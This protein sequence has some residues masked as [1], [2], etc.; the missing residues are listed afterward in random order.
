MSNA[1]DD[2]SAPTA[3]PAPDK[4]GALACVR[5]RIAAVADCRTMQ[6][7]AVSKT[8][9]AAAVRAAYDAGQ[10]AFGDNYVHE[11]VRKAEELASDIVW[12]FM[13]E[14]LVLFFVAMMIGLVLAL[15]LNFKLVETFGLSKLPIHKLLLT[16]FVMLVV[17]QIATF[18][19]ARRAAN[20]SPSIATRTV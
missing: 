19:P 1:G 10:R 5:A 17:G 20:I 9:P 4:A 3:P 14:N 8:K 16:S 2:T 6:L 7:V 13:L 11:L 15:G 18:L 12:H